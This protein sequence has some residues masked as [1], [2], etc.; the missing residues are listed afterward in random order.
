MYIIYLYAFFVSS[1]TNNALLCR[2]SKATELMKLFNI[3]RPI[4]NKINVKIKREL[5]SSSLEITN[6]LNQFFSTIGMRFK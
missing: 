5:N 3:F 6:D 4:E 1:Y 2:S